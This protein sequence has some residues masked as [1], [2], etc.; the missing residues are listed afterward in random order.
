MTS[1]F[2]RNNSVRTWGQA[3]RSGDIKADIK[4]DFLSVLSQVLINIG[5]NALFFQLLTLCPNEII[6]SQVSHWYQFPEDAQ[7]N[8]LRPNLPLSLNNHLDIYLELNTSQT[9]FLLF[10]QK[11]YLLLHLHPGC[12]V[13]LNR[14]EEDSYLSSQ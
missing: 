6:S 14:L 12:T 1:C 3:K 10:P 7:I 4:I 2:L 9:E 13:F 8:I 5:W 11:L